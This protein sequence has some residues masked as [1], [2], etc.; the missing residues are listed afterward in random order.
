MTGLRPE[1]TGG[2]LR[3][4]L[5]LAFT[6]EQLSIIT[7]PLAPQLVVAGAGS[8]KTA[9]MAARVVHLVAW[10][11]VAPAA[12][13][14]L[15]FTNKAAVELAQRVRLA[16]AT[17][18]TVSSESEPE[19]DDAEPTVSTYH[20]Y[21]ARLLADHALRIGREPLTTL[22]TEAGRWQLASRV[23]NAAVGPFEALEWKPPTVARYLLSLDAEMS[24]HMTT[25][26][27]V[28][29]CNASLRAQVAALEDPPK[30]VQAVAGAA[31]A[32]EEL[33]DL[34]QDYRRRKVDLD[35]IDYGDQVALAAEIATR[36]PEVGAL[37]RDRYQVVVL[38]EYQDT[39]VAQRLLL[40]ALFSGNGH[41]VT[42][43]GD[44]CQS[45][46]GW[47]GASVGN[48]L[49]FGQHFGGPEL[50]DRPAQFLMTSFRN[51]GRILDVANVLS[52]PLRAA[53]PDSRRPHL[54]VPVLSVP[55]GREGVGEVRCGWHLTVLDE[56]GWVGEQIERAVRDEHVEPG[57]VAVLCRR[58]SDFGL[59]HE[60]LVR[61]NLPVEVVGLGGLV[62]VPEVADVV[63]TLEVLADPT[64]NAAL[65][66]LLT[67]P[68]WRI[69][70]RDLAALGRH[71]AALAAGTSRH[72][73]D[74]DGDPDGRGGFR[75]ATSAVDPCDVVALADALDAL[76]PGDHRYS[77]EGR[78]R[79]RALA[80]E[81]AML[82]PLITQ[83]IVEAVSGVVTA[84]GLD[85]EIEAQPPPIAAARAA[86]L[87]A[88]LDHAG[89]FAGLDGEADLV[90]FL[91]FLQ[92]AAE[93]EDGLDI[94]AVATTE[95]IKLLTVHKAKGLEW[96]M[97]VV[98]GLCEDVFP[99]GQGR[100]LWTSAARA[101]PHQLRGDCDDLPPDPELSRKE[102]VGFRK[103]CRDDDLEEE[104]RL[105]YVAVTRARH[106]L[107]AS[108]YHWGLT[109][110]CAKA[111]S[112]FL[113]DIHAACR[114]GAGSV[115]VWV[116]LPGEG[117]PLTGAAVDV[118]WPAPFQPDALARRRAA[119]QAV[120][121]ALAAGAGPRPTEAE[122][123]AQPGR[124]R[125]AAWAAE[126]NLLLEELG[127]SSATDRLV[128]LPRS[129]TASQV[130]RLAAD[131]NGLAQS[132]ARPM[133]V[134]PNPA[135]R[136][137]TRF[138]AWVEHLF[139]ERP[140]FDAEALP[141]AADADVPADEE[142]AALQQAFA[143]SAYAGVRPYAVEAP[144]ELFVG[145][146]SIRGR[147]DAVY[148]TP[149]GYDVID[150]KTG[151]TPRDPRSAALQLA[152]YR[153]AWAGIAEVRL[154]EVDAGFLYLRTG[155]IT[156]P[157]DLPDQAGL[158]RLLASGDA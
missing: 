122:P 38:D 105:A 56:A 128:P 58:R 18:G 75:R 14:G 144:F 37:E 123:T 48:L 39:G 80:A 26:D 78:G 151:L 137:G 23:V 43:V 91:A 130:V 4:L 25:P 41:P 83:P 152:I 114:A 155:E 27:D 92:A 13:L 29:R 104:R 136:R 16:L 124:D 67:G 53:R 88:F 106:R 45:I 101:L 112:P 98:P 132:L 62:E 145:G 113:A 118:V 68:R 76:R 95:T 66:R 84:I 71:A 135:A 34:V 156:R 63:A 42:A 100:P 61:R 24:E 154:D 47:R 94:G 147:I 8:G 32:R 99:S 111:L 50:G 89:A 7:A 1:P 31:R 109:Q 12:V 102:V 153:L 97:V 139:D 148:R 3:A 87:A 35:L 103:L 64:A 6:E 22:L 157:P 60:E 150:Y 17:L 20:A 74:E 46:Y 70:P 2:Y 127:S 52:G 9:V 110:V 54:G 126:G 44:P 79:L 131:P 119:A 86:N 77:P 82:R 10:Y 143:H 134:R 69:G 90:G 108:G 49:R 5:G 40:A 30:D 142:L 65:M 51:D 19:P 120:L 115:D 158:E 117:N 72:G 73:P 140:L 133:P 85:V 149:A 96:D 81:L 146:R 57:Q 107:L 33:L 11:G 141:G 116:E 28:R 36:R 21:A 93:A 129:L 125:V 138:H 15:T 121:D 55:G 59:L